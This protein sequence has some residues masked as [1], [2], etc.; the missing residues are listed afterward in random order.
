M[1]Y[2]HV[3]IEDLRWMLS[4]LRSSELRAEDLVAAYMQENPESSKHDAIVFAYKQA[5]TQ[6]GQEKSRA[7]AR[8]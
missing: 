4:L 8:T 1:T 6:V 3:K 5:R 2:E 7:S